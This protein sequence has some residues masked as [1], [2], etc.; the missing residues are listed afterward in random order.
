MIPWCLPDVPSTL[1]DALPRVT[2]APFACC[3]FSQVQGHHIEQPGLNPDSQVGQQPG[4]P[5]S[6]RERM[7]LEV[8]RGSLRHC[9]MV[10]CVDIVHPMNQLQRED[11]PGVPAGQRLERVTAESPL[12]QRNT[13]HSRIIDQ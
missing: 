12:V 5:A 1:H 9:L 4:F 11:V 10:G 3:I 13:I 2:I 7:G 8:Q 6:G